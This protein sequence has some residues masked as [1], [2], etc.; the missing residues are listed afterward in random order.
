MACLWITASRQPRCTWNYRRGR[1]SIQTLKKKS[2]AYRS[3]CPSRSP[4]RQ[5]EHTAGARTCLM[6]WARGESARQDHVVAVNHF[7]L[8]GVAEQTFKFT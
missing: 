4:D 8:C 5:V 7:R 2:T 6:E 3:L 1:L